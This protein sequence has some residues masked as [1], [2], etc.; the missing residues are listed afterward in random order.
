MVAYRTCVTNQHTSAICWFVTF[1][2]WTTRSSIVISLQFFGVLPQLIEV[3]VIGL[4]Q[5]ICKQGYRALR[6]SV[7]F[8]FFFL[9]FWPT[10]LFFRMKNTGMHAN[11][12]WYDDSRQCESECK[13]GRWW[14]APTWLEWSIIDFPPFEAVVK[15]RLFRRFLQT[16]CLV[17]IDPFS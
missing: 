14:G 16:P 10:S 17:F 1:V 15:N 2:I 5:L 4:A 6:R 7:F 13:Q 3:P 12:G 8:L 9:F 11:M